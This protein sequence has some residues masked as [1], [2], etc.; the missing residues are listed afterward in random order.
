MADTATSPSSLSRQ[1]QARIRR[2][3]RQAKVREG[4]NSRLNRI[5]A[6]QGTDFR[7]A[8]LE[9]SESAAARSPS[10]APQVDEIHDDPPENEIPRFLGPLTSRPSALEAHQAAHFAPKTSPEDEL[11][12]AYMMDQLFGL[13]GRESDFGAGGGFPGMDGMPPG[14]ENM[15]GGMMGEMGGI[16][17]IGGM[18]GMGGIGGGGSQTVESGRNRWDMW[19]TVL[20]TLGAIVLS[21]WAL[22]SNPGVFDGTEISRTES[23]NL[24]RSEKPQ[25]FWYFALMELLLQS[26]RFL[27]EKGRPP[28]GSMLTTVAGFLPPP[29]SIYLSTLARYSVFLW[30]ILADA[31]VVIFALGIAS[32]WNS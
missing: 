23:A 13:R 12:E 29:F 2:E 11:R 10:P 20:H 19:W 18:G 21:L 14:M 24:A 3:R 22:K 5:T 1:E 30:T 8:E 6:T 26:G 7:K 15:V 32:W 9:S 27:L 31:G 16:G 17:G 25:L 28:Q 4:G